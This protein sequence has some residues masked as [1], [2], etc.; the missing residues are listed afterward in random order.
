M[1]GCEY[2]QYFDVTTADDLEKVADLLHDE[3]LDIREIHYDAQTGVLEAPFKRIFHGGP[4]GL[5]KNRFIYRIEEVDVLR[6]CLRFKEVIDYEIRDREQIGTYT[7]DGLHFDPMQG[8]LTVQCCPNCEL[9]IRIRGINAEYTELEYR[10]KAR[11]TS[12][13]WWETAP[14]ALD[15]QS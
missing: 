1:V 15:E 12:G 5:I 7:F 8:V 10:G 6:G 2:L 9:L 13:W 14:G 4:R 3:Y 11:I